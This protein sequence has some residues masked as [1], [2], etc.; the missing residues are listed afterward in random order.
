MIMG[1]LNDFV[2]GWFKVQVH[3]RTRADGG[4]TGRRTGPFR[5]L[6]N[7]AVTFLQLVT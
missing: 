1:Q 3:G 4:R 6:S 5:A 7:F 2:V